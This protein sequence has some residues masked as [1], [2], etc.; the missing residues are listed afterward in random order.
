[1]PNTNC[2]AGMKCPS[3]GYEECFDINVTTTVR[4]RDDGS[5]PDSGSGSDI[6]WDGTSLCHCG[7]CSFFSQ[8]KDFREEESNGGSDQDQL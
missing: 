6:E 7:A 8:V 1:M 2:L 4:M 5:D 3:C